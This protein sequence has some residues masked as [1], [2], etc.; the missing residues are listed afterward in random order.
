MT[1]RALEE[2]EIICA[3]INS[4]HEMKMSERERE[5]QFSSYMNYKTERK[6]AKM[7]KKCAVNERRRICLQKCFHP[8]NP[9]A[10]ME[11]WWYIKF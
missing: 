10:Q 5:G 9:L 2:E 3:R 4:V 1:F 11:K 7:D 6:K 8:G